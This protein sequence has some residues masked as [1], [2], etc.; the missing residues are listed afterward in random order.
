MMN[1]GNGSDALLFEL[2]GGD[3]ICDTEAMGGDCSCSGSD[4]IG[5]ETRL[6]F[7]TS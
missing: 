4:E 3:S 5:G 2:L 1:F 7:T 6:H